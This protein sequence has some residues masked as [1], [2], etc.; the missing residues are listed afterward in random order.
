MTIAHFFVE[1]LEDDRAGLLCRDGEIGAGHPVDKIPFEHRGV[2]SDD[3]A[4]LLGRK[5]CSRWEGGE[6]VICDAV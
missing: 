4:P 3:P 2:T 5:M 1:I 6:K